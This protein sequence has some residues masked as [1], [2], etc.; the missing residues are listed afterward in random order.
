MTPGDLILRGQ[1]ETQSIVH[2]AVGDIQYSPARVYTNSSGNDNALQRAQ[3]ALASRESTETYVERG[4]AYCR[5]GDLMAALSDFN[6]AI[7]VNVGNARA[8]HNRGIVHILLERPDAAIA[9]FTD[10][11]RINPH[12][13]LAYVNRALAYT[14]IG[15]QTY[16]EADLVKAKELGWQPNT[17]GQPYSPPTHS[18]WSN[19]DYA[20]KQNRDDTE[21][22]RAASEKYYLNRAKNL[23]RA[24]SG[25]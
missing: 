5:K 11:I 10:A 25:Q 22:I 1:S 12:Y 15:L 14:K 6:V 13:A 18:A 19:D 24:K 3:Q 23:N 16:A 9:D 17:G 2:S 7:R 8:Y 21:R 20:N 4:V